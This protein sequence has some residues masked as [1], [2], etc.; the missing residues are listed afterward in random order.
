MTRR[1]VIF[2]RW[3]GAALAALLAAACADTVAP[4]APVAALDL[5]PAQPQLFPDSVIQL[6]ATPRDADGVALTGRTIA[7]QSLDSTIAKVSATGLARGVAPGQTTIRATAD[8]VVASVA[9][10]VLAPVVTI[11]VSSGADSVRTADST[12]VGVNLEDA[13]GQ[14]IFGR[15][16]TWTSS[17]PTTATVTATG[18]QNSQVHAVKTGSVTV[19]ATA[20]GKTGSKTIK[21]IARVASVSLQPDSVSGNLGQTT[22]LTVTV[23][24]AAGSVITGRTV[25][26]APVGLAAVTSGGVVTLGQAGTGQVIATVDGKADTIPTMA[27][28]DATAAVLTAGDTHTCVISTAGTTYC[29]GLAFYGQL[30]AQAGASSAGSAVKNLATGL[31]TITTT[32]Q[33]NCGLDSSN[34]MLCW[35]INDLG[36]LGNPAGMTTCIYGT[37]CRGTPLTTVDT[38]TGFVA[39][40]TGGAH[41]CGVATTGTMYCWGASLVGALGRGTADTAFQRPFGPPVAGGLSF[42]A[43][44][45]GEYHTCGLVAGGAAWC[46][47]Q[48]AAGELGI[49]VTPNSTGP[50]YPTPLAVVG[51][52][53]F[54]AIRAA[55]LQTCALT[56]AGAAYCWGYLVPGGGMSSPQSVPGGRVFASL[57]VGQVHACGIQAD[58]QAFCWGDDQFGQLGDGGSSMLSSIP[59]PVAGGRTWL[60]L[61]AGAYH[62]CGIDSAHKVWCWG[63]GTQGELGINNNLV[64]RTPL[65]ALGQR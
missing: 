18:V 22:A 39:L 33:H 53:S 49:G 47:G 8:T 62:T 61:A 29:W 46:W 44:A 20:E 57:T 16:V 1:R 14:P 42:T 9:V 32:R 5:T 50:G 12:G 60:A 65:L 40:A 34:R 56:T 28:M 37:P 10:R 38:V 48:N 64:T 52:L 15:P 45:A 19:T 35:G 4:L 2:D 36:Q 3:A 26:Y 13:G 25:T 24:D 59:L 7:W 41:T 54:S 31:T 58:G 27:Y 6:V 11:V 23:R 30:G 51:G 43:L 63:E 55:S 17:D 21:V